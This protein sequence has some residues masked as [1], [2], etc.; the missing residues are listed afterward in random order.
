LK[1]GLPDWAN[2]R[3]LGD[4]LHLAVF[5]SKSGMYVDVS[6]VLREYF[7]IYY[8]PVSRTNDFGWKC[9][10]FWQKCEFGWKSKKTLDKSVKIRACQIKF[11]ME[12]AWQNFP[13]FSIGWKLKKD[14][15]YK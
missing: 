4:Y 13:K 7:E 3:Q 6:L 9:Q 5:F 15:G 8:R 1:S 10:R 2:F 14:F 11:P 12:L